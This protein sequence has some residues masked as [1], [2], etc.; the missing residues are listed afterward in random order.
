MNKFKIILLI[1]SIF[2]Q[3]C[4]LLWFFY[5]KSEIFLIVNNFFIL[6]N[7]Q[8]LSQIIDSQPSTIS[9]KIFTL[10]W[11]GLLFIILSWCTIIRWIYLSW[12]K[13]S[14]ILC[15]IIP[16]IIWFLVDLWF[17]RIALRKN[18]AKSENKDIIDW[19]IIIFISCCVITTIAIY[20]HRWYNDEIS[21]LVSITK[22][23]FK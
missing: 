18:K 21:L 22:L 7:I 16:T 13:L 11:Y 14:S 2:I 1:I 9:Y 19:I 15:L 17:K 4:L 6:V 23:I 8:I 20:N 12:W 5:G 3:I 10:F